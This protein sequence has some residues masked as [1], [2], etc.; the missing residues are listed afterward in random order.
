M[1]LFPNFPQLYSTHIFFKCQAH[2]GKNPGKHLVWG[3]R[4]FKSGLKLGLPQSE[5]IP[6]HCLILE[7]KKKTIYSLICQK[8]SVPWLS[9]MLGTLSNS[10]TCAMNGCACFILCYHPSDLA[11]SL[12]INTNNAEL[13]T[14]RHCSI[15]L[16]GTT[17]ERSALVDNSIARVL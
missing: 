9:L 10:T 16:F 8:K 3:K 1:R 4:A 2:R 6:W 12:R 5:Q 13:W 17:R 7:R 14:K 15:F 11:S